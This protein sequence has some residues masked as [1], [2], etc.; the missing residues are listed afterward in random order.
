MSASGIS[1]VMKVVMQMITSRTAQGAAMGLT[2]GEIMEMMGADREKT[3]SEAREAVRLRFPMDN[4]EDV[5]S[6]ARQV[7]ATFAGGDLLIPSHK[8]GS[9]YIANY[10]VIDFRKVRHWVDDSYRSQKT[11]DAAFR[12][13][14]A[15]GQAAGRRRATWSR[16]L[17]RS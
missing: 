5:E 7:E 13:G 2:A 17:N 15:A 10:Y 12:R 1:T 8:D 11:V 4:D 3:L 16:N 14:F 9:P 6:I